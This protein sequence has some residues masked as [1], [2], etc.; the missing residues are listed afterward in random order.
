MSAGC[1]SA[2]ATS[3]QDKGNAGCTRPRNSG[4]R[5]QAR[6][7]V[8]APG[9]YDMISARIADGMGF[10][11]LYMT[12]YGVSAS[13]GPA[14]RRPRQLHRDGRARRPD[15]PGHVDARSSATPIPASAASSTWSARCR[16]TR[17]A[18]AAAH[19]ARGPG[20]PQEAAATRRAGAWCPIEEMVRKIE[21]AAAI[22]RLARLPDRRPHRRAH[23]P[24]PRRG[25]A[26]RR[27]LC[28]GRRRHPVHR[29]PRERGGDGADRPQLRP[30]AHR[31]HGGGRAH[32]RAA[33]EAAGGA[34]LQDRHLSRHRLPRGGAR[35]WSGSTA[36]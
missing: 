28:Q 2:H 7:L 36:C 3:R 5:W 23:Q 12:G 30:A 35:R 24:R 19:P 6:G 27:G 26:A 16:A 14:R 32:A 9:V 34:R 31:Q 17:R 25:A 20:V 29:E 18:G 8:T 11:A 22:A 1:A 21:V 15:L 13:L 4:R 10:S 33:E